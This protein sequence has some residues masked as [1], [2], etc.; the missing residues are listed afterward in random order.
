MNYSKHRQNIRYLLPILIILIALSARLIPGPRT[1][2]DAYITYRYTQNILAGEGLVYNAGENVL[3]TTTPFYAGLMALLGW[4]FG[5]VDAPFPIVS[6]VV[7]AIADAATC[8]LLL[9]LGK[10]L[11]VPLAGT[12]AAL[13]W[14][15]HP[16]SVTFAIGGLETSVFV[17]VLM[18][19]ITAHLEN[20]RVLTA[21]L[22][23]LSLLTR[24]D[25]AL[26]LLPLG[27]DRLFLAIR[28]KDR[29][30]F[31]EVA[32]FTI[33]ILAWIIPAT[34]YYGSPIPHSIAAKINAYALPSEAAFV[35]FLQHYSTPFMEN[36]TFGAAGIAAGLFIYLFFN[37][38]GMLRLIRSNPRVWAW[39]VFPWLWF[40]AYSIAN[41]LIF[42][43][44]LTPPLA[45]YIFTL[46]AGMDFLQQDISK[47]RLKSITKP[48]A[49]LILFAPI[50]LLLR[51]W[52]LSPDHGSS[53]PA[54]DMAWIQLE[55]KY[56]EATD[57]LQPIFE[58]LTE[59]PTIAAGDIGALGYYTNARILDT[60]G[61]ISPEAIPYYPT[62]PD[63]YVI[64]YA[65]SPDLIIDQ[66]PDYIVL[67]EVYGREG[68]FKNKIFLD[69]YVLL[70]TVDT[71]IY[72]SNGMVIYAR[73]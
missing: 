44:Y 65:V 22:A 29:I 30:T 7:N 47:G 24:P 52:T 21:F 26:L 12:A 54:P 70:H 38:T 28:S 61:L 73:K 69:T 56:K 4:F 67:L 41:P 51:G 20:K 37:V 31:A 60:L 34:L 59:T 5:G 58:G 45:A 8:L 1:I 53:S 62:L 13:A 68:L 42:R 10:R 49:A 32:A 25:A 33:P 23:A 63:Y 27:A 16:Y 14:A 2:D 18:G 43:W 39:V 50:L 19:L 66:L 17:L 40:A 11:D 57:F 71:D 6:L 72:G 35:R 36:L 3:G 55:L 15:L 9:Q 48:F 46:L 64:A